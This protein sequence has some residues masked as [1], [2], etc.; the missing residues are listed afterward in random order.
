[1]RGHD[2]LGPPLQVQIDGSLDGAAAGRRGQLRQHQVDQVGRLKGKAGNPARGRL[3]PDGLRG[4]GRQFVGAAQAQLPQAFQHQ[5]LAPQQSRP[6]GTVGVQGP[7]GP[8][9]GR[10]QGGLA[11]VQLGRRLAEIEPGRGLHPDQ[12]VAHGHPV[13]VAAQDLRLAQAQ[14]NPAAAH[15]LHQLA[16]V[17]ASSRI[18]QPGQLHGDGGGPGDDAPGADIAAQGPQHGQGI[19]PRMAPE[20]LVFRGHEGRHHPCRQLA[21]GQLDQFAAFGLQPQAQDPALAVQHQGP[22]DRVQGRPVKARRRLEVPAQND[23]QADRQPQPP[24]AA[25]AAVAFLS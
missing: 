7:R 24:A 9:Q 6:A 19:D 25:K 15:H 10:Q 22:G 16:V 4:R 1:M 11:D 21:R 8:G 12:V 23:D 13:Q 18:G 5:F 14:L 3:Q 17:S 20:P 2:G